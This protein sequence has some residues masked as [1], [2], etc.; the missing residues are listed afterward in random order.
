MRVSC[1]LTTKKKPQLIEPF[2]FI[3]CFLLVNNM[4]YEMYHIS[5]LAQQFYDAFIL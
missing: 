2:C 4:K 5:L 3:A 1:M